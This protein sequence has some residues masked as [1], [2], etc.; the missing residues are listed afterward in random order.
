M[1]RKLGLFRI[2]QWPRWA[3]IPLGIGLVGCIVVLGLVLGPVGHALSPQ[4]VEVT[5][6]LQAINYTPPAQSEGC[7]NCHFSLSALQASAEDPATAEMYL[8]ELSS[9][10]QPHGKLGCVTCHEG[11]GLAEDKETAHQGLVAD[12]SVDHPDR[13]L[14]CHKDLPS[15]V[16]VDQLRTPHTTL[17]GQVQHGD[18]CKVYC[19]D[20]HGA[21]GHGFDPTSGQTL[22]PMSTCLNCHAQN[23]SC[24]D[25]HQ[26]NFT[27]GQVSDGISPTG[28]FTTTNPVVGDVALLPGAESAVSGCNV[29]H[30]GPHDVSARLS[31]NCCHTSTTTWDEINLAVHPVPLTGKHGEIDCFD[32]HRWPNFGGM[33]YICTDCHEPAHEDWGDH[34]CTECHEPGG[35]W[36]DVVQVWPGHTEYWDQYRGAHLKVDC[37]GCHFETFTEMNPSCDACHERPESHDP[38]LTDCLDCH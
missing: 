23:E 37:R 2:R 20:C 35:K 26:S 19:S 33:R 13:C 34:N 14:V 28:S 25:C 5:P 10:A 11:N 27:S 30:I 16:L 32:C 36:E 21:V 9:L 12:M 7:Q 18:S 6:T 24:L 15:E 17:A 38:D 8:I 1:S 31:C 22:C 3:I 29:C 4:V